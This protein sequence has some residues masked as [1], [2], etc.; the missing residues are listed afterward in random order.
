MAG[1][2]PAIHVLLSAISDSEAERPRPHCLKRRRGWPAQWPTMTKERDAVTNYRV[3]VTKE[4]D[5][6]T[7]YRATVTQERVI[8]TKY[9]VTVQRFWVLTDPTRMPR[10]ERERTPCS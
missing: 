6:V 10:H 8:V 2:V 7:T 4:H 5:A 3:M 1:L 9:P